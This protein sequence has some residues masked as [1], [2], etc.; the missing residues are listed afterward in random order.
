M[1]HSYFLAQPAVLSA[2][3]GGSNVVTASDW[4]QVITDVTAQFS[5][6]QIVGVMSALVVAGIGFVFLWWGARKA[7]KAI[8]SAVRKGKTGF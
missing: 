2:G 8:M 5:I 1:L 7:Y 4:A 6:T 3:G